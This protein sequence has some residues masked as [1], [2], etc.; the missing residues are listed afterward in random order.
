VRGAFG[1]PARPWSAFRCG[2]ACS[3]FEHERLL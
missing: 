3:G 1:E 2:V